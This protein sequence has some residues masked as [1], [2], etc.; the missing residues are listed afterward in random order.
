VLTPP[1]TAIRRARRSAWPPFPSAGRYPAGSG[2]VAGAAES[3]Q[4]MPTAAAWP[5]E[6]PTPTLCSC[7][8]TGPY[9][10]APSPLA[11]DTMTGQR[12]VAVGSRINSDVC[13]RR[14]RWLR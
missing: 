3:L 9:G 7:V 11:V 10:T 1:N 2:A 4:H 12:V 8:F 6:D 5:K 14:R 13:T